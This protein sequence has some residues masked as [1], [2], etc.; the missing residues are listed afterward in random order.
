MFHTIV[1]TEFILNWPIWSNLTE[2]ILLSFSPPTTEEHL[3]ASSF[4]S[5]CGGPFL[6]VAVINR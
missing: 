5:L 4:L 1:V 6:F 3:I 2:S